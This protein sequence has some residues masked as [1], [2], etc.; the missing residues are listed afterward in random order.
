MSLSEIISKQE[1]IR[2]LS[3]PYPAALQLTMGAK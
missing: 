3:I 1:F 2:A